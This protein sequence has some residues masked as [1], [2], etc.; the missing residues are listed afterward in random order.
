VRLILHDFAGHPFPAQL[1]RALA[2]R[3]HEVLHLHAAAN[4]TP[5]GALLRRSDDAPGLAF[6]ALGRGLGYARYDFVGRWR[7][8][9]AYGQ[10]LARRIAAWRPEA[11]LF[12]NT[13]LDV[14]APAYRAADAVGARAVLWVQDLLGLAARRILGRKMPVLGGIIGRWHEAME[15]GFARRSHA[16]IA[17]TPD[18][19]PILRSWGV[20]AARISVEPNWGPLGEIAPGPRENAWAR[21]HGLGTAPVFLYTG[22]MGLK[23]DPGLV[24]ALARHVTGRASVVVVSEGRGADILAAAAQTERL[25]ALKVVPFQPYEALGQVL[26]SGDVMLAVLEREAG[27]FAVPSKILG[28]LCAAR[29]VLAALPAENQAARLLENTGAG[30]VVDPADEEGWLR[31]ADRLLADP[32]LR[33]RMGDAGRRHAEAAFPIEAIA[34]RFEAVLAGR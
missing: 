29:P 19:V 24:L 2:R 4:P 9:R 14:L 10:A 17:I 5:K 32:G 8:E 21:A 7:D 22:M 15:H 16:V 25:D 6:E 27:I 18:F 26:A 12:C 28:Y 13:P 11:V 34:R 30:V 33:A 23:H 31:A 1:A 3:G 20:A